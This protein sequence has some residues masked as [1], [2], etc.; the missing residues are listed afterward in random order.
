MSAIPARGSQLR[1]DTHP[2]CPAAC[3]TLDNRLRTS[4]WQS[5]H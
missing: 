5:V 4:E 2:E 1:F 3:L